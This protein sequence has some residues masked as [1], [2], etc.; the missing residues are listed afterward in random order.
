SADTRR[1]ACPSVLKAEHKL[2]SRRCSR[3]S[4]LSTMR[5][6]LQ[7]VQQEIRQRIT[8]RRT[9]FPSQLRFNVHFTPERYALLARVGLKEIHDRSKQLFDGLRLRRRTLFSRKIQQ[10]RYALAQSI[11]FAND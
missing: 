11:R 4:N 2:S 10:L 3:Q 9:R 6:R 7:R 1:H 8:Q 5:R